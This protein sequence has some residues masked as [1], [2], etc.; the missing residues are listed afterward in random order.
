[1]AKKPRSSIGTVYVQA[2]ISARGSLDALGKDLDRT[3]GKLEKTLG[4]GLGD[5][6]APL[7]KV[8]EDLGK[9]AKDLEK[10]KF[11]EP[12]KMPPVV[13]TVPKAT[14]RTMGRDAANAIGPALSKG[15]T[16]AG[17]R[18]NRN[19]KR[20]AV[21]T[22]GTIGGAATA[23]LA[24][25]LKKGWDRA[26]NIDT[27][28]AKLE[29]LGHTTEGIKQIM[30]DALSSVSGTAYGLAD[31]V[32]VGSTAVAAGVK[33]GKE[34]AKYL[35][36]IADGATIAG[37]PLNEMGSILNKVRIGGKLLSMELNQL[38]DRGLPVTSWLMEDLGD[39]AEEL[40][41]KM[42]KGLITFEDLS[43]V[44]EKNLGGAA[45]S[46][47]D[48]VQGSIDNVGAA[49][50]R[51]GAV[52]WTSSGVFDLIRPMNAEL[53]SFFDVLSKKIGPA[54]ESLSQRVV[55][56]LSTR[57]EGMGE[58]VANLLTGLLEGEGIFNDIK[59]AWEEDWKSPLTEIWEAGKEVFI[60]YIGI[61][62]DFRPVIEQIGKIIAENP[63]TVGQ[64]LA[65]G[66]VLNTMFGALGSVFNAVKPI[67]TFLPKLWRFLGPFA[68]I[69]V[70]FA[71]P[72]GLAV[73]AIMLLWDAFRNWEGIKKIF[74][75]IGNWFT[76]LWSGDGGVGEW[77]RGVGK[78]ISDFFAGIGNWFSRV[79][80]AIG[81][82]FAPVYDAIAGIVQP[83]FGIFTKIY[84][85]IWRV[86]TGI[87]K[88]MYNILSPVWEAV[89]NVG[90]SVAE[91]L[92]N[93]WRGVWEG[94]KNVATGIWTAVENAWAA[95]GGKVL[96]WLADIGSSVWDW[97]SEAWNRVTDF[98][99]GLISGWLG[100]LEWVWGWFGDF[101]S[102]I[103]NVLGDVEGFVDNVMTGIENI[104][105]NIGDFFK[106]II[107]GLIGFINNGI[108]GIN[109]LIS[110]LNNIGI[111]L[112]DWLGGGSWHVSI[113]TISNIPSL[114]TGGLVTRPTV[115]L[116][117]DT[118]SGEY[119]VDRGVLD[120]Y[121]RATTALID[122]GSVG[123]GAQPIVHN[124]FSIVQNNGENSE[125]F[126]RRVA[127]L[128][129][130]YSDWDSS[131]RDRMMG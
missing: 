8:T 61:M 17:H 129:A 45:K 7:G 93:V 94:I 116:V 58:K 35:G 84:G 25:S 50:G 112:P 26:V 115:A 55:P 20:L 47:G 109:Q 48:T 124:E 80:D 105:S 10:V 60:S 121:L 51:F 114:A 9:A 120:S 18:F 91:W 104:G 31:A 2:K 40:R 66:L 90:K 71:G 113:P 21:G 56:T 119:V 72:I 19:L 29:G 1:M 92:G 95:S 32:T 57:L 123:A 98:F 122:S 4:K 3:F 85:I 96:A 76:G 99:S 59:S 78:S 110:G 89:F 67:V 126:A 77:L 79:G 74:S 86:W 33:P 127:E 14:W 118:P 22:V 117:G 52:L 15:L 131:K 65:W 53:M 88:F 106:G 54:L 38:Q 36:L 102:G 44:L 64:A 39:S 37:V 100:A 97:I 6:V 63:E 83:I 42:R 62:K 12:P 43:R 28:Q 49:M 41:E 73:G 128:V 69:G 30:D 27:A 108:N 68:K 34:L 46:S 5:A 111:D 125:D 16:N 107:N 23:A 101:L 70:R 103:E 87:A 130:Q 75:G 82:A 13:P 81:D 24:V 11:P